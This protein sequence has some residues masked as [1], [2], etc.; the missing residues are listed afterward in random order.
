MK[1]LTGPLTPRRQVVTVG[2]QSA[3]VCAIPLLN[4][5]PAHARSNYKMQITTPPATAERGMARTLGIP[6]CADLSG[7]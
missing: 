1:L 6:S 2:P 3:A 4:A 7:R 5:L